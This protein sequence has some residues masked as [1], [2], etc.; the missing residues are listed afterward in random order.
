MK[1]KV[2]IGSLVLSGILVLIPTL[3]NVSVK[4]EE[5]DKA[6][7]YFEEFIKTDVSGQITYESKPLYNEKLEESGRQYD[8][9]VEGRNGYALLTEITGNG[10]TL[11]EVE[12]LFYDK[13]SPFEMCNGVPVY[14]TH[15]LYLDYIDGRFYDLLSGT[16]V[17]EEVVKEKA[18]KGFGYGGG[19]YYEDRIETIDYARK[20]P[21]EY[22]IKYDLPNYCGK[23]G[24]TSCANTAGAVLL[25]YYDRFNE[26]LIPN[27]K[28]YTKLGSVLKYKTKS[29]EIVGLTEELQALMAVTD[30]EGT[31]YAEFQDGMEKYVSSHGYTYST[32]NLFSWGSFDFEKYRQSVENDKPVAIFLNGFAFLKNIEEK[33]STDTVN[34]SYCALTHVAVGCGYKRDTYYDASNRVITTRTY[35]KVAS[36]LSDYNIGYLNINS[37]GN[38]DRAISVLIQ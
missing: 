36:V 12:E 28:T 15:R 33:E 4:A 18:Y 38:I 14:I 35:L 3:G 25:G 24:E 1:G 27:Y 9:T 31:T 5:L 2:V 20:V 21:Q 32:A 37:L 22:S 26:N 17:D 23:I 8:F 30:G 11:Y 6:D 16:E 10:K 19:G 34:S 29:E 7:Q 13:I